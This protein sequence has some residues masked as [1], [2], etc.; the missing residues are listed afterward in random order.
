MKLR[1]SLVPGRSSPRDGVQRESV[2]GQRDPSFRM[3]AHFKTRPCTAE[4]CVVGKS[5][6]FF[7]T[8]LHGKKTE[9]TAA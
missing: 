6:H 1:I 3:E 9:P 8:I 5:P 2:Y 4:G 7:L